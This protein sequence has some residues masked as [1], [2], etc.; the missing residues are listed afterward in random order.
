MHTGSLDLIFHG[1]QQAAPAR[2]IR[3]FQSLHWMV[4][5]AHGRN[6]LHRD[7]DY[8]CKYVLKILEV[9]I[10]GTIRWATLL[11]HL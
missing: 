9:G 1:L 11:T 2:R 7:T 4:G 10:I 6:W 3:Y 5:I 8:R